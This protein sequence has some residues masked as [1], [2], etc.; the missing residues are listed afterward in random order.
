MFVVLLSEAFKAGAVSKVQTS[1]GFL[2]TLTDGSHANILPSA[3]SKARRL[4]KET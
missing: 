2:S 1:L 3:P 4:M